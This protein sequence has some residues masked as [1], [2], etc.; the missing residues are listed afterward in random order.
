M[1]K[2]IIAGLLSAA[3]T[4]V[5]VP[6][7][8]FAAS[9]ILLQAGHVKAACKAGTE[10]SVP[11]SASVNGG[12]GAGTVDLKWDQTALKLKSVKY[13]DIAPE[14]NPA[15]PTE[16]GSYRACFGSYTAKENY[17]ATGEFF[18]MTF[19]VT[20]TAKPGDYAIIMDKPSVFDAKMQPVTASVKAG[21]VSLT[22]EAADDGLRLEAGTAEAV[23]G[24]PGMI[25]VPVKAAKNQGFAAGTVDVLW[26]SD[27]LTLAKVEFSELASDNS[28][29]PIVSDGN[30]RVAF[31][32]YMKKE[33]VTGTGTLFTL[34]F[35]VNSGTAA[36]NYP[37]V[38]GSFDVRAGDLSR[39]PVTAKSGA[40]ILKAKTTVTSTTQTATVTT[41]TST[42]KLTTTVK[43]STIAKPT[44]TVKT[45]TTAKPT[46][47]VK[48]STTAKPTTTVKTSTTAK[49]TTT[50][51]TSTTAK[52]TTT[53]STSTTAK[54][55]TPVS[56]STTAKPTTTVKT[57]TTAK[58]TTTVKTSTTAK[59][60][61]TVKTSTTA[62]PTTTVSTST[63]AKPTTTVST[64]TTAKPTTT[65][66][67]STTAKPTTTVSTSTT[68]K[69]T[70]TVSTSTTAKPTTTVSTS[71]TAKPTTTVKTSTT[72]K[73]TTTVSTS[74]TAKPTTTVSTSTTAKP[75]TTVS[76]STTAKPTTT[77]KTS[78]TAKPTTTVSTSTTAKPT[79]TVSTSTTAKPTTTVSTSTASQPTETVSAETVTSTSTTQSSATETTVTTTE[80]QPAQ[81]EF[82]LGD[83]NDDGEVSVDDAQLTLLEYVEVMSGLEGSFTEKQK[84]AGDINGDRDVSVDDAQNILIYYV[85]N[86]LSGESVT[87]DDLTGKKT[88]PPRPVQQLLRRLLF[89]R[90][91]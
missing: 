6:F 80:T 10:V 16:K 88:A 31:G 28:S 61:T 59:P 87:W 37:V 81:P 12:Y 32:S 58:P 11:V 62:K 14:N 83:V 69:P 54:P 29:A 41:A 51:K 36:G 3:L 76:T 52:P 50:V 2:R 27:A 8:A 60:T 47:T 53:V 85:S 70:T 25:R 46:T 78:T 24:E 9:G 26:D 33:N 68:A 84:L 48:T 43:T 91:R 56:T 1:K 23:I 30:Y 66:K 20:D 15:E 18:L 17:T 35:M 89:R 72:A 71:T 64:S 90:E 82:L 77:V 19:T 74:T 13:A 5:T 63:T 49:P 79:T 57:S 65:V 34:V 22:G 38:L 44:T 75:T 21:S 55:T 40:V 7:E 67:T 42:S 39:V 4:V 73:P 86:T 45:S